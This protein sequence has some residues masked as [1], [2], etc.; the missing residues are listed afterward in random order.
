MAQSFDDQ[1]RHAAKIAGRKIGAVLPDE[2]RAEVE[3]LRDSIR[4][5]GMR[6]V[7]KDE[8][9]AILRRT[10]AQRRVMRFRYHAR[11]GADA[12]AEPTTREVEPYALAHMGGAWYLT[13][14]D[15]RRAAMRTFRLERM[16][17]VEVLDRTFIRPEALNLRWPGVESRPIE[18]RALFTQEVAR[19]V[20]EARSFF[21]VAE[22]DMA[23]G[24]LVTLQV[25]REEEILSWLL[26]WGRNVRVLA[27]D[28]LRGRMAEEGEALRIAHSADHSAR[29][30]MR[31]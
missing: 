9:L 2:V 19:W 5:V 14:H 27:P 22:E 28:S 24:L 21:T 23:D 7:S 13:G 17:G 11:H 18:V 4:F 26:S 31:R 3:L 8:T 20:R 1:Y 29:T 12:A 6:E 25:R 10:I 15:A 16:E 30:S